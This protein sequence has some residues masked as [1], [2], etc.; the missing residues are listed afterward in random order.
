MKKINDTIGDSL[1]NGLSTMQ[2]VYVVFLMVI[3]PLIIAR[4]HDL[5][6][7]IQY[8]SQTI[9]QATA[10]PLLAYNTKKTGNE[11]TSVLKDNHDISMNELQI[12]KEQQSIAQE[13]RQEL[14]DLVQQGIEER[15][16]I[17]TILA[18]MQ[19]LLNK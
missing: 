18:D 13:E 12:I 14:K 4:P 10:L 11:Q 2:A 15:A 9:L 17:K 7:W 19:V 3:V 16:D 8:V 5:I 1:S 6:G